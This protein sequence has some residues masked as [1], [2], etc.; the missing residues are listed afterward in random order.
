MALQ[1]KGLRRKGGSKIRSPLGRTSPGG[2]IK[3]A[4]NIGGISKNRPKHGGATVGGVSK[5]RPKAGGTVGSYT[6]PGVKTAPGSG[7]AK[8]R[9]VR[10]KPIPGRKAAPDQGNMP[11]SKIRQPN[12]AEKGRQIAAK[13]KVFA[14]KRANKLANQKKLAARKRG[15][16]RKRKMA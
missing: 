4:P 10:G 13:K 8:A 12:R 15:L 6:P 5:A 9:P 3:S 7:G 14:Q 1:T 11:G 2:R 16:A